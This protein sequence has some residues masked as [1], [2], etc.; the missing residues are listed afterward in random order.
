MPDKFIDSFNAFKVNGS[1][2]TFEVKKIRNSFIVVE[3][4]P[5]LELLIYFKLIIV[6]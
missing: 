6:F 1:L 2:C 4:F 3:R 5:I